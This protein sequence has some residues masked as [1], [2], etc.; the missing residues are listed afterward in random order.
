MLDPEDKQVA[1]SVQTDGR[2][3]ASEALFRGFF[4][5]APDAVIIVDRR[6]TIVLVNAQT[7]RLFGYERAEIVGQPVEVLVPERFRARHPQHR[8]HYFADL[9]VRSM[10]SGLELYG[11]RKDGTE[12]P[13]EISLSPLETPEGVLV[14]SAIR[15]ITDRKLAEEKFRGLLEA[16][17]DAIVIVDREGCIVLLNAQTEKLFGHPRAE[18]IGKSVEMLVPERY[19]DKHPGHRAGYFADPR[20]RSMGSSLELYGLRRD[21]TEFPVEISLSPLETREGLLVSGAI[22]DITER[23]RAEDKFRALLEAAP[24]AIVIVNRYGSIVLVNAQTEKLFGYARQELLGQAIEKLVPESFRAKHPKHRAAFFAEPKVRSMGS[25]LELRGHRKDGTEFPIEISLSPLETE[26]GTLVSSAIRDITERKKAEEKF[27]GLLESAPDAMVIVGNDGRILLVNAQTEKLFGYAREE[28]LG[29]WVELLVPERFRKRH[30]GH[31]AAY[32]VNPRPRSM[33]SGLELFG[34]RK[35]RTE[36]P[37]EISLSPLETHDGVI[38]SSAIRDIT[39]RKQMEAAAKLLAGRLGSAVESIQDA[40]ALFDE[41]D[42]L[43]LCNSAYGRLIGDSLPGPG[44]GQSYET[45][46]D[47]WLEDIVFPGPAEQKQ[48]RA[49]RLTRPRRKQTT[50]TD[51]RMRDGRSLRLVERRTAEGGTVIT[52]WDLTDDVRNAEELREARATAETASAAK[53]E[54]L[55]SMSHELRTPLNAILGFAQLLQRDKKEPLS[56]RHKDRVGEIL[57]GGRHLLRLIDDILDLSRIEAGGVS[58]SVEPVHLGEVLAEVVRTLEPMAALQSVRIHVDSLPPDVPVVAADR[59]RFAQILM[60][61]GSNAIKYNRVGGTVTIAVSARPPE[62][63]RVAV[64]DTGMGIPVEKQPKLFQ[65]FQRAGQETGPIQGTGIGLVITKR[66][67]ELMGGDVGF[68]SVSG[69]GS[70]FWVDLPQHSAGNTSSAPPPAPEG[71]MGQRVVLEGRRLVLYVEDNPANVAFMDDL[72]GTLEN[73]DLLTAPTAE[74]GI[75]LALSRLPHLVLLDINLPGMGGV[76]A[77]HALRALP[78]TKH[79]P[80]IAL[81]AAASEREKERGMR[82]GFYRYLTKPLKLDEF[83]AALEAVLALTK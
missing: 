65:P 77:L 20:V 28:L 78:E 64:R 24:D 79:I 67:A 80:V 41:S 5:A 35:D 74:M 30:P 73:I 70:E 18:L 68:R 14:S 48:F 50:A 32:F 49:E 53:S 44:V 17:P 37:I 42:R 29:Q 33:G 4:E 2:N 62:R 8:T 16:A 72:V 58:I 66:L 60:N 54:F 38:V 7:E 75:E 9:R 52:I 15:D 36:F 1:A 13:V 59:T 22:R 3:G 26:E 83:V 39:D 45:L 63:L 43:V 27:K 51:I 82:A 25:G 55:S 40:F 81:T 47:A 57:R 71:E 34:L 6:G 21:G 31:R 76:E 23:K 69:E 46:L 11:L 10:G 61:F 56:E 19:R 12:F